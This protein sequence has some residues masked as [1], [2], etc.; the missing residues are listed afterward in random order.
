MIPPCPTKVS[1]LSR[2]KVQGLKPEVQGV[3][4]SLKEKDLP[5]FLMQAFP[6]LWELPL[7]MWNDHRDGR[8]SMADACS[9]PPDAEVHLDHDEDGKSNS[10]RWISKSNCTTVRFL[11]TV[12]I[13]SAWIDL[14]VSL[15]LQFLPRCLYIWQIFFCHAGR[16]HD[17]PEK[18]WTTLPDQQGPIWPLLPPC[19][20]SQTIIN[21]HQCWKKDWDFLFNGVKSIW[22]LVCSFSVCTHK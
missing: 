9:N 8:C 6:G 7:V 17:D 3:N 1:I 21:H 14:K 20:V 22:R 2:S 16:L 15:C 11:S 18:L 4:K 5:P 10:W 19:L 12:I 13:T